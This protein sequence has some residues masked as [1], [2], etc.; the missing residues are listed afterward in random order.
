[1]KISM[2]SITKT[3]MK[4]LKNLCSSQKLKFLKKNRSSIII[5]IPTKKWVLGLDL[6]CLMMI[7]PNLIKK[8]ITA[9]KKKNSL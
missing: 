9:N 4:S 7:W 5:P 2:C 3:L 6:N 8:Q 1:M